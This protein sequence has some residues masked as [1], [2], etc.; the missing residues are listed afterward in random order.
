MVTGAE[1]GV[2]VLVAVEKLLQILAQGYDDLG[3]GF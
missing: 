2:A 1:V 3:C